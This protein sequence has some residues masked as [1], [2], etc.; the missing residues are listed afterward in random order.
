MGKNHS[1]RLGLAGKWLIEATSRLE[2]EARSGDMLVWISGGYDTN[3]C[4]FSVIF[5]FFHI[6]N[7][8]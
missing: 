5:N 3:T 4:E 8:E 6:Y 1:T 2:K 7:K